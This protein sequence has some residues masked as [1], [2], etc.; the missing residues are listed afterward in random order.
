[1]HGPVVS[2][3]RKELPLLI[4]HSPPGPFGVEKN[5]STLPATEPRGLVPIPTA[6][7]RL[8]SQQSLLHTDV[9]TLAT[10]FILSALQ[11][12][13]VQQ[14]LS[15]PDDRASNGCISLFRDMILFV[16]PLNAELNPICCLLALLAHHFLHVSRIRVK[17]LTLRLLMSYIYIY[18]I[19]IYILYIYMT[20]VA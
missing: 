3:P 5:V 11:V 8:M 17:S 9:R 18:I 16:D 7:Y 12:D 10:F 6:L 2:R 4:V 20:L 1:M 13:P 15:S 19:Y 14:C